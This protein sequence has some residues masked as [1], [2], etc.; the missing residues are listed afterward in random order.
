MVLVEI[1]MVLV[2]ILMVL[3]EILIVLVEILMVLVEILMVLV[4]ILM[5]LVEILGLGPI[6]M[7]RTDK[8]TLRL[9]S[10]EYMQIDWFDLFNRIEQAHRTTNVPSLACTNIEE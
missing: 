8:N 5:V 3:V 9:L 4:E 2:E 7:N 6:F 10:R 1:L